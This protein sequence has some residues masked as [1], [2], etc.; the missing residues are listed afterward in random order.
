VAEARQRPTETEGRFGGKG[1]G[2]NRRQ[3]ESW[4]GMEVPDCGR[5]AYACIGCSVYNKYEPSATTD[6]EHINMDEYHQ[7]SSFPYA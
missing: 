4:G 1:K 5:R 3:E 2:R 6:S 7:N